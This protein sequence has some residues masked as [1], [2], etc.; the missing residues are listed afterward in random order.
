MEAAM[1]AAANPF[2][3]RNGRGLIRLIGPPLFAWSGR[4]YPMPA[5]AFAIIA[6]LTTEPG[7]SLPRHRVRDCLWGEFPQEKASANLRQTLARVRKIE[8]DI[9]TSI[10]IVDPDTITLNT[11][12]FDIDLADALAVNVQELLDS[13]DLVRLEEFVEVI[14][15][16]FLSGIEVADG[17]F[18]S[19]QA[20][21]R[22]RLEL[23]AILAIS[24]LIVGKTGK[25]H[26][27]TRQRL[28]R[29]LLH[30]DPTRE[31][32][33][34]TLM[35]TYDAQG[36]RALALQAY[37]RCC[38]VLWNEL[39]TEPESD[40]RRLAASLGF[41]DFGRL[42]VQVAPEKAERSDA[43][44]GLGHKLNDHR[45]PGA[46]RIVLF[47]PLV[48]GKT[49]GIAKLAAALV[50]D[51][52]TG[53]TRCRS[54]TVV[55]PHT[56]IRMAPGGIEPDRT[57]PG[58]NIRYTVNT[59]IKPSSPEW[60]ATF[61]LT[62]SETGAVLWATELK[63]GL[64][65]LPLLFSRLSHQVI[66][67]LADAI[68]RAEMRFPFAARNSTAYRLYLEGRSAM[69]SSDLPD[70]RR[71]RGWY[72]KSLD[73]FGSYAPAIAGLSRTM[74]MERLVRGLT[75]DMLLKE[76]LALG[77]LAADLD[78][79]D[80][81]GLRECAFSCLYLKRHDECLYDFERAAALNPNDADLLA[82][83]ADALAHA[84]QPERGHEMCLKA[85]DLNPLGPDY[86]HWILGSIHYQRGEY[87]SAIKALGPV[88]H[89]VA[90]ARL[91]AA[92]CAMAGNN[93]EARRYAAVVLETYPGF[94]LDDLFRIVPDK[95]PSDTQHL[96][97][98]LRLAGVQ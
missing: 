42:R 28:A 78:P 55:A 25:N 92:S 1:R 43:E 65:Q 47:P 18:E 96:I 82:D 73:E 17:R 86:Y 39:R 80:G 63:F 57:E 15:G 83:Y 94:D 16:E 41:V 8:Q 3:T 34:R 23:G 13:Q 70:L 52:I 31:L 5:K 32:A 59:T 11:E 7:V 20:E 48:V 54:F 90:T 88:K 44:A 38:D 85:M 91:L 76:A 66:Y 50:E 67:S 6:L 84:G 14:S 95:H 27:E 19:W 36:E 69:S 60:A 46:P 29:K 72:R 77:K 9:G 74:S 30:I 64:D 37:R 45:T 58:L 71:A 81:R 4:S 89:H 2:L 61:R 87:E 26:L 75:E 68:E 22:D 97:E 10:L 79:F 98:G 93:E 21:I 62:N 33:Y 53:L 24:A 40:T 49:R 51:V 35:E 12:P 56:S